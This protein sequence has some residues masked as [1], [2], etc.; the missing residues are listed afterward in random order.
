MLEELVVVAGPASLGNSSA[1]PWGVVLMDRSGEAE[2]TMDYSELRDRARAY[3]GSW[4]V[5]HTERETRWT[6]LRAHGPYSANH[7]YEGAEFARVYM[8][9]ATV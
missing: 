8:Q 5:S 4:L 3:G 9:A 6:Q 2:H 1:P 7:S